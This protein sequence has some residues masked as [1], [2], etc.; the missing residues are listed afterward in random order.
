MAILPTNEVISSS[1]VGD[2]RYFPPLRSCSLKSCEICVKHARS[3]G[4]EHAQFHAQFGLELASELL[5]PSLPV[6]F[7]KSSDENVDNESFDAPE[8]YTGYVGISDAVK[9]G[10]TKL[11]HVL[12]K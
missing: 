10:R 5:L 2:N 12:I 8:K 9:S 1:C 6:F 3:E 11:E 7:H 4:T